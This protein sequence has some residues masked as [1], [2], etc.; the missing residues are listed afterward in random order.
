MQRTVGN[1][2][3]ACY[4]LSTCVVRTIW[5]VELI[6]SEFRRHVGNIAA[7]LKAPRTVSIWL[8][9]WLMAVV[10]GPFGS[11]QTMTPGL[12]L[13]YWGLLIVSGLLL[14]TLARAAFLTLSTRP[15]SWRS[16]FGTALVTASV[17]APLIYVLRA[18]LDPVL[19]LSDLSLASIWLNT[20]AVVFVILLLRRQLGLA[21]DTIAVPRSRLARR[22]PDPL[23]DAAL[24]RLSGRDHSVEVVTERGTETLRLRLSDAIEEAAPVEGICI[25]RSHWVA[26]GAIASAER[27]QG[28]TFVTLRNGERIPVSRSYA[29]LLE[30]AGLLPPREAGE[31]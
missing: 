18:G 5:G 27:A 2:S 9:V 10:A 15:P 13:I 12:R 1:F 19:R 28:K 14:S 11:F 21:T 23:R 26:R 25:H 3:L 24:L 17:L 6:W 31:S 7:S 16:D 4:V 30:A 22:L 29:P 20:V 8:C